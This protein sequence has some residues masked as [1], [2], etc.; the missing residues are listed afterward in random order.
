MR[1]DRAEFTTQTSTDLQSWAWLGP[2]SPHHAP[3]TPGDQQK[4]KNDFMLNVF[5]NEHILN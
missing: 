1:A 5:M 2:P 3:P 4:E